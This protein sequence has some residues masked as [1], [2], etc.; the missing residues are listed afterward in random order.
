MLII[1]DRS[2]CLEHH[3]ETYC[4]ERYAKPRNPTYPGTQH[5]FSNADLAV[6]DR[7]R[8]PAIQ[9]AISP[10][11]PSPVCPQAA[12]VL[13]LPCFPPS[14]PT[15]RISHMEMGKFESSLA[16]GKEQKTALSDAGEEGHS[17]SDA[18]CI[19][20]PFFQDHCH[21]NQMG[22]GGFGLLPKNAIE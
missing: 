15:A 20:L 8:Q 18:L 16:I 6:Q 11:P 3:F 9:P 2:Y 21:H 22:L 12:S 17:N 14:H 7:F 4:L 13:V 10:P 1:A 19:C 5:A